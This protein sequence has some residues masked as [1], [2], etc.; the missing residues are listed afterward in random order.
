MKDTV[1]ERWGW[2]CGWNY[3]SGNVDGWG[4]GWGS[5]DGWG[6][7]NGTGDGCLCFTK[8]TLENG[9]GTGSMY[10][11]ETSLGTGDGSGDGWGEGTGDG[12]GIMVSLRH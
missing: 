4:C 11:F 1:A 9:Y 3:S 12:Q 6:N 7:T 10:G 2:S 5:A 8:D